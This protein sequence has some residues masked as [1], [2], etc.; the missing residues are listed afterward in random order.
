[1]KKKILFVC[2]GLGFGGIEKCLVN[3]INNMAEKKYD[4]DLLLMNP[5]TE[6]K[7]DIQR[8]INYIDSFKYVMNTTD[9]YSEIKYRGGII[10]NFGRF[11]E[12]CIFRISNKLR[13]PVWKLF[14]KLPEKYDI[15]V[16]YS[17]NDCSPYYVIDKVSARRKVM[18]YHNGAY[19]A[20]EKKFHRDLK[21]YSKFDYVVAV[22]SDCKQVLQ[23]YFKLNENRLIVLRNFCDMKLIC[24]EAKKF[25]PKTYDNS[26]IN[27]VS[28]G[29]MT[30]E[31]GTELAVDA[32]E[33]L[34]KKEM[35]ICWHWVG[36]GNCKNEILKKIREKNLNDDFIL[37]GNQKN[38]Y[39]YIN[40]ADIYVQP[41][42]YEAYSTTVTEAKVLNKVIVA[43]DVGG[44][45]EQIYDGENGKIVPI[46]AVE[47]AKAVKK[48]IENRELADLFMKNLQKENIYMDQVMKAYEATVFSEIK[49]NK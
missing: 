33:W 19:E 20:S 18:W 28:V 30:K 13:L 11:I 21:Y 22:S 5:E 49:R 26:K 39:P 25:V 8:K 24:E 46:D 10:K 34:K 4:I 7:S 16:A 36:D 40:N 12:Y 31:K 14:R 27:I 15:A 38:P 42:F 41:S 32:C 43:T 6:L 45:R 48:L 29:R 1:M 23:R 9:T 47:I 44:M 3:L 2:Y 35:G 37:E 17:Q